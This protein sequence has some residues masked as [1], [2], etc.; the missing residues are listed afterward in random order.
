L[1]LVRCR[2]QKRTGDG[3]ADRFGDLNGHGTRAVIK[4]HNLLGE[5]AG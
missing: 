5:S 2:R 1:T 4:N 3:I